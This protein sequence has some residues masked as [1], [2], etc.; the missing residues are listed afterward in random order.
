MAP[1]Q[2]PFA[3]SMPLVGPK[4]RKTCERKSWVITFLPYLAF[5]CASPA[6]YLKGPLPQAALPPIE[7][8]IEK[9]GP[10]SKGLVLEGTLSQLHKLGPEKEGFIDNFRGSVGRTTFGPPP[11]FGIAAVLEGKEE[12]VLLDIKTYVDLRGMDLPRGALV[13]L[14]LSFE[15]EGTK[16]YLEDEEGPILIAWAGSKAPRPRP[17]DPVSVQETYRE[18]YRE[19]LSGKDLCGRT[20]VHRALNFRSSLDENRIPPG[21]VATLCGAY[22]F[23]YKAIVVEARVTEERECPGKKA[24]YVSFILFRLQPD[25]K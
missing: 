7:V 21:G 24:S 16:L 12:K 25:S 1:G 23:C 18:A 5:A 4:A 10:G 17:D 9:E 8:R 14:G 2:L 11:H 3:T 19:V 20:V 15:N 13:S 22:G 6:Q